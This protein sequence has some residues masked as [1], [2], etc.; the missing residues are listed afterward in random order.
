M[1]LRASQEPVL[2]QGEPGTGK[3]LVARALHFHSDKRDRPFVK[4]NLA[5]LDSSMLNKLFFETLPDNGADTGPANDGEISAAAC[6]TIF[7]DEIEALPAVYQS[8]LLNI[9][10]DGYFQ[11]RK[12]GPSG[13]KSDRG[14]M[15]VVGDNLLQ[16]RVFEGGS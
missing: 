7:L 8:R 10:E 9:F 1:N 16:Q 15:V 11:D 5:R 3:E 2:I 14:R 12:P 4:I 6:G 13:L